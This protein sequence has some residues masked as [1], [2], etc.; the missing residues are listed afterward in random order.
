MTSQSAPHIHPALSHQEDW[1][2]RWNEEF[3]EG[4]TL[5]QDS[6]RRG[7]WVED[8]IRGLAV[9]TPEII[10]IDC[11]TGWLSHRLTSF[12][13]VTATD[14]AGDVVARAAKHYPNIDFRA[15]NFEALGFEKGAYDAAISLE[16]L[17]HVEV[18]PRFVAAI[19]EILKPGGYLFLTSQNYRVCAD[20]ALGL[21][22]TARSAVTSP[23]QN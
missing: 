19:A 15:G 2:N 8:R 22:E 10:D 5:D 4:R 13:R 16:T 21:P 3:R 12:G 23:W 14:L 6:E 17:S 18:Q 7:Q 1:W 11:G 20:C 9:A